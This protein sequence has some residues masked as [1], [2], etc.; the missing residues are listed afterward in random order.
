MVSI[1]LPEKAAALIEHLELERYGTHDKLLVDFPDNPVY[2]ALDLNRG[3]ARTFFNP[4]T[5]LAFLERITQR[6]SGSGSGGGLQE[7]G[8]ILAKWNKGQ[9]LSSLLSSQCIALDVCAHAPLGLGKFLLTVAHR[10]LCLHTTRN[11]RCLLAFYIPPKQSQALL[12]GG[13]FVFCGNQTLFA[14]YDPSTAAHASI[15]R[16]MDIAQK[17]AIATATANA[18]TTMTRQ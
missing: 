8:A 1:G 18:T 17:A 9:S 13:T 2:D 7:L 12:Q 16:V 3:L 10:R 6:N 15:D 14:H 4:A 11:T 5:P